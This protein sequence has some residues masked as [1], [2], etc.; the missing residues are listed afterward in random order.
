MINIQ[1][2]ILINLIL[3]RYNQNIIRDNF[4]ILFGLYH[5]INL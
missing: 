3:S 2:I 5:L 1:I 4:L